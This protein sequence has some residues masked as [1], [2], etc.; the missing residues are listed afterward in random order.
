MIAVV[1]RSHVV[2]RSQPPPPTAVWSPD[3]SP[4]TQKHLPQLRRRTPR[5]QLKSTQRT[6]EYSTTQLLGSYY[7]A[8]L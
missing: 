1:M 4:R 8:L 6:Q 7:S 5:P 3:P 2:P